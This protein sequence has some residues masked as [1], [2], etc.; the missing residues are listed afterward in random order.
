MSN[1]A[2]FAC[3]LVSTVL[4]NSDA[5]SRSEIWISANSKKCSQ[6]GKYIEKTGGGN[7]MTC[8]CG[9]QFCWLC[10][11]DW[12]GHDRS[13]CGRLERELE[14]KQG[15]AK[16][17][18]ENFK[19]FEIKFPIL[20][21]TINS[22]EGYLNLFENSIKKNKNI[23]FDRQILSGILEFIRESW[24]SVYYGF[25]LGL[26]KTKVRKA[27][28][29]EKICSKINDFLL[30]IMNFFK[31]DDEKSLKSFIQFLKEEKNVRNLLD[32]KEHLR[33]LQ[34]LFVDMKILKKENFCL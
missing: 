11:S 2:P 30:P 15:H 31:N 13:I 3:N 17:V 20:Q 16:K 34:E 28:K 26:F 24:I 23:K 14:N 12:M 8:T 4:E 10:L 25:N 7:L 32:L 1:H 5:I 19:R 18:N 33:T 9:R 22:C 29:I 21:E 6:C 27:E